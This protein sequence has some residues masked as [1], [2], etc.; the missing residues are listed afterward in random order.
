MK[1]ITKSLVMIAAVAALAIGGTVAY[2]SDTEESTGNTFTAG[3]LI[4]Q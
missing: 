4:L 2:F 1:N 3:Q